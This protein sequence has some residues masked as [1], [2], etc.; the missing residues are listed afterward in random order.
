MHHGQSCPPE[1][2]GEGKGRIV[3]RGGRIQATWAGGVASFSTGPFLTWS[4]LSD[5]MLTLAG[6]RGQNPY[7]PVRTFWMGRR[8]LLKQSFILPMAKSFSFSKQQCKLVLVLNLFQPPKSQARI[9]SVGRQRVLEQLK[10]PG[11]RSLER[12]TRQGFQQD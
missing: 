9:P 4:K 6:R 2:E 12:N 10:R 1:H 11:L 8:L 3:R 7:L 5:A